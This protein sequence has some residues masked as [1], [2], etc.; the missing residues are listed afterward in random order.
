MA[1][2]EEPKLDLKVLDA[3]ILKVLAYKP[4]LFQWL[5]EFGQR[6]YTGSAQL[7]RA[8]AQP[9][10]QVRQSVDALNEW[11]QNRKRPANPQE[12]PREGCR[13]LEVAGGP[14]PAVKR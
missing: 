11:G 4:K 5:Q 7:E 3:I 12:S 9:I 2:K 1:G 10:A 13:R 8:F 6:I 14:Y